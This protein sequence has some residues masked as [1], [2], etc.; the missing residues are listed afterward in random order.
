MKKITLL[1][2]GLLMVVSLALSQV[3]GPKLPDN[4]LETFKPLTSKGLLDPSR[5]T[6]VHSYSVLYASDGRHSTVQNLY[7][8]SSKFDLTNN[9]SLHLDLGYRFNPLSTSKAGDKA[10][11]PNAQLRFTPNEHFLIEMN[12]RTLDPYFY[13]YSR[14]PWDR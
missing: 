14:S 5:F 12:Y 7:V 8:N 3:Q 10:F 6:M 4:S 1:S 2:I 11:L 9:L 13:G